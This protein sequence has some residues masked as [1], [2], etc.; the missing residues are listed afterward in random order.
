[1]ELK[2]LSPILLTP[3]VARV[4][5]QGAVLKGEAIKDLV[6]NALIYGLLRKDKELFDE[7]YKKL[8]WWKDFYGEN[9]EN[10]PELLRQLKAIALW[11]E[12]KVL[13]GGEPEIVNGEVINFD[14]KK[15]L[16]NFVKA[17]D[18]VLKEGKVEEQKVKLVGR[19]KKFLKPQKGVSKG[20]TFEGELSVDE[21]YK[22]L[23]EPSLAAEY[24]DN[25]AETLNRYS[26]KILEIGKAFFADRGYSKTVRRLED[27][28]AESGDRLWKI[29]VEEGVLPYAVEVFAYERLETPKGR[30]EYLHLGE[31]FEI[32]TAER[33]T[34][35]IFKEVRKISPDGYPFGWLSQI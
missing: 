32:L 31:I 17:G 27:I 25:L 12:K 5:S 20:S 18:F 28:E 1:M 14:E 16:L 2:S 22:E 11:L 24:L 4:D 33:W 8:L 10:R 15:N 29:N 9:K 19:V 3:E 13:C 21:S 26:L 34:G 30:K 35:D 7:F 23:N 6:K